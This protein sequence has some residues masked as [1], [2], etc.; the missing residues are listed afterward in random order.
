MPNG[1]PGKKPPAPLVPRLNYI[2]RRAL[3]MLVHCQPR[4]CTE[5]AMI[6]HGIT[7]DTLADLV[8]SGLAAAYRDTVLAGHKTVKVVR[9]RITDAGLRALQGDALR[10][11]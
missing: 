6:A 7:F 1:T 10:R 5:A 2:Q 9:L 11:S 4:G 8:R 3:A